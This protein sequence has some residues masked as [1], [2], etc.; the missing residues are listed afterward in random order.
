MALVSN[1][2]GRKSPSTVRKRLALTDC[3]GSHEIMRLKFSNPMDHQKDTMHVYACT[4]GCATLPTTH[5]SCGPLLFASI[6]FRMSSAI[7][8]INGTVAKL[9]LKQV[10]IK[11]SSKHSQVKEW[12]VHDIWH[13]HCHGL[14]QNCQ[15]LFALIEFVRR[16]FIIYRHGFNHHPSFWVLTFINTSPIIP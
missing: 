8:L 9:N 4:V 12:D 3:R 5:P 13:L 16:R 1:G 15:G 14:K 2:A 11:H 7:E 10:R 6:C